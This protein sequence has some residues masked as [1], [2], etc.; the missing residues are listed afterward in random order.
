MRKWCIGLAMATVM[1]ATVGCSKS[2]Q[3]K[4]VTTD[5]PDDGLLKLLTVG[6][7]TGCDDI[8]E[9][10]LEEYVVDSVARVRS[11]VRKEVHQVECR[12]YGE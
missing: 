8:K 11:I 5:V 12:D 7:S 3:C 1:V 6:G 10:A 2:H 4:C 9:W